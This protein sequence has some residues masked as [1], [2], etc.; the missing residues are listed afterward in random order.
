LYAVKSAWFTLLDSFFKS[1]CF[2]LSI[3]YNSPSNY[4][5]LSYEVDCNSCY[6][7]RFYSFLSSSLLLLFSLS[8]A[9][10][11]CLN[12]LIVSF[13]VETAWRIC[14]SYFFLSSYSLTKVALRSIKVIKSVDCKE[15]FASSWF[16]RYLDFRL[17][18][19]S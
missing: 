6:F 5:I 9:S 14:Y 11:M 7:W 12:I 17:S 13:V 10:W 18:E 4:A 8:I 19:C 16:S 1:L 15:V 3:F 2:L